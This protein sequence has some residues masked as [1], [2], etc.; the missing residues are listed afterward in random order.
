VQYLRVR[1]QID[2]P[3]RYRA[4]GHISLRGSLKFL[5]NDNAARFLYPAQRRCPVAVIAGNNYG[6][7]F[8]IPMLRQG[9][10][11]NSDAV[12]PSPRL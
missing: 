11:E 8:A 2:A 4:L 5:R 12:R 3:G 7:K 6:D 1:E 10:Q 9:S